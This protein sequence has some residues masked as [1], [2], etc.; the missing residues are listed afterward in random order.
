MFGPPPSN[1]ATSSLSQHGFARNC[2]WE[3]LGKSTS[4]SGAL[5]KGGDDCVKLDFGLGSSNLDASSRKAWPYDFALVYSVTL[6]RDRLQTTLHVQ[7]KGKEAFEFQMLLH[8][9]LKIKVSFSVSTHP[10]PMA[11]PCN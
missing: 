4:E 11:A 7:N 10:G 5:S 9:Y 8:T 2:K 1:H 3:F 6:G